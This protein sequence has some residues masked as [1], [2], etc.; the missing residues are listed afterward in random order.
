MRT[1]SDHLACVRSPAL[2]LL[3]I[4]TAILTE[5]WRSRPGA[6]PSTKRG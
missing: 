4:H 1:D 2:E 6:R 3:L 5:E